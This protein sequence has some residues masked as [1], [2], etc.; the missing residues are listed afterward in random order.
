MEEIYRKEV[1]MSGKSSI[2]KSILLLGI[3]FSLEIGSSCY[4]QDAEYV[5]MKT[6][7]LEDGVSVT[8]IDDNLQEKL[9][10]RRL[11]REAP[12]SLIEKLSLQDGIPSSVS[13]FLVETNGIKIL[14]DTGLGQPDS[15][16]LNRLQKLGI[17]PADIQ[18]LFLTH[19]HGDHIGGMMNDGQVVFPNAQVY[20]SR[21]EYDAW[22]NMPSDRNSQQV[23]TMEAYKNQLHLFEFGDTLPGNVLTVDAIGH[24]PGHTAF[25]IG[26]L[27]I[28]GDLF[29]G[30]ALQLK[31]PDICAAFDMDKAE[32][33]K[34]RKR[35]LNYAKEN[36][37]LMAGMHLPAPA[38][39]KAE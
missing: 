11:F 1:G 22:M 4:A 35:I 26:Q 20:A 9:M 25:R 37:L 2:W 23:K 36:H 33:V 30:V 5:G 3:L 28:I 32:A 31:Y 10:E 17:N 21:V 38:F 29:H 27:L 6:L 8:W 15:Q 16:L 12:D 13:T 39:L 14:F 7:Q 19:F 24:T 34:S 18:Y